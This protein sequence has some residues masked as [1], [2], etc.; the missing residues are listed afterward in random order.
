MEFLR[1]HLSPED[2]TRLKVVV[3][4]SSVVGEGSAT[5]SLP[6][7]GHAKRMTTIFKILENK[8]LEESAYEPSYF[9][10]NEKD[11]MYKNGLLDE[12]QRDFSSTFQEKIGQM[13]FCSL[14]PEGSEVR[15]LLQ[16]A[17]SITQKQGK[18]LHLQIKAENDAGHLVPVFDYPWELLHNGEDYLASLGV[19]ISR[20]IAYKTVP[21]ALPQVQQIN[22]LLICSR[23]YDRENGLPELPEE[24][25]GKVHESLEKVDQDGLISLKVLEKAAFGNLGTYL[26]LHRDGEVPHVIHFDGHGLIGRRCQKQSCKKVY[27]GVE[28]KTC[29][30]GAEL[31]KP[32]GY[33]LFEDE[34]DIHKADYIS[35]HTLADRLLLANR[36]DE[37]NQQASVVLIVLSAC[38]SGV[39]F[40]AD[41]VFNGVAQSLIRV[42][43]PVVVGMQFSVSVAG[44]ARFTD[45]FYQ[46]LNQ[47]DSLLEALTRS[48]EDMGFENNQWY[49][50]VLYLRSLDDSGGKIFTNHPG[51]HNGGKIKTSNGILDAAF[52]YQSEMLKKQRELMTISH[53]FDVGNEV[54]GDRC[55]YA[56]RFLNTVQEIIQ[57]FSG[58]LRD[59]ASSERRVDL[60]QFRYSLVT[61]LDTG[62]QL[63]NDL[64]RLL[65]AFTTINTRSRNGMMRQ[66]VISKA[67]HDLT[68]CVREV[69]KHIA[70]YE[71]LLK[72]NSTKLKS[73]Y[74]KLGVPYKDMLADSNEMKM[75][76]LIEYCK[77]TNRYEKLVQEVLEE[78]LAG[79]NN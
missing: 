17:I 57:K 45:K 15:S 58:A 20:Y 21:P 5:T 4:Q 50:P 67:L 71:T 77:R 9:S 70:L 46:S 65:P 36:S 55:A 66:A 12:G 75:S 43:I 61:P 35:A 41:S 8:A 48:R 38:Q 23:A 22:V 69:H 79:L 53:W 72:I 24:G 39:S 26:T 16:N 1:I 49:R 62:I 44:A 34:Q 56:A 73:L 51:P 54:G 33:L 6:F 13:L 42:Q 64:A 74:L 18:L 78:H 10:D 2:T 76:K 7:D 59:A 40:G 68:D 14:F 19:A 37:G 47:C 32:E 30:C 28:Q 11:W 27:P 52:Q 29:T 60:V 25:Y 31:D 63:L 3:E